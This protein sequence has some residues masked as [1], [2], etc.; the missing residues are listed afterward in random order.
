MKKIDSD[1]IYEWHT[2]HEQKNKENK[3]TYVHMYRVWGVYS[4]CIDAGTHTY[5]Y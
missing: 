1:R 3:Q 5:I 4:V 2:D